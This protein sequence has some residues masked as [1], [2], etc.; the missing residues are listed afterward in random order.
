L[1]I[2]LNPHPELPSQPTTPPVSPY[3]PPKSKLIES[4]FSLDVRLWSPN[5]CAN[6]SLIFTPAFGS[7]LQHLNWK[8]LGETENANT[9][10]IWFTISLGLYL[11]LPF[12]VFAFSD[13][14]RVGVIARGLGFWYLIIWYFANG[15]AQAKYVKQ[16]YGND[17]SRQSWS[18]PLLVGLG[19][20]VGYFIYS[21]LVGLFIAFFRH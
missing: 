20:L 13:S 18:Q 14:D 15:R 9:S 6:W 5:A 2:E 16:Q 7:Y 8:S 1:E 3:A 4:D 11:L 21:F 10:K 17:Y 12:V 19:S